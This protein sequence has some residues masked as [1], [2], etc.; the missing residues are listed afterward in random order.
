MLR[1]LRITLE[2]PADASNRELRRAGVLT[3]PVAALLMV[4]LPVVAIAIGLGALAPPLALPG[5]MLWCYGMHRLLWGASANDP[6]SQR[7][8]KAIVSAVAGFVSIAILS[9]VL[10]VVAGL[11]V[12]MAK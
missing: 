8:M 6:W 11:V 7:I 2:P 4:A 5:L 3:L 10:G 9:G 1:T 12:G